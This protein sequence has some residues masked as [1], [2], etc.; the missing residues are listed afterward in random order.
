MK[1]YG[2]SPV[3]S[4]CKCKKHQKLKRASRPKE[5][6]SARVKAKSVIRDILTMEEA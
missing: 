4:T 2:G 5:R 1:P 3:R 6:T